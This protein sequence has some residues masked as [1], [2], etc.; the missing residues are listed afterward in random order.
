MSFEM[1]KNRNDCFSFAV[2]EDS[3]KMMKFKKTAQREEK[4]CFDKKNCL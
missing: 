1:E 4:R 3:R 2:I